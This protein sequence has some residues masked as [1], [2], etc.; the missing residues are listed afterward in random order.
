[1]CNTV[2]FTERREAF[3]SQNLRVDRVIVSTWTID[4]FSKIFDYQ[5]FI[6]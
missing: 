5:I 1:M 6:F 4:Q 3:Y 2:F